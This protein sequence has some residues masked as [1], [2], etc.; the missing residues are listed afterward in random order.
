MGETD[1]VQS[2]MQTVAQN[3]SIRVQ[4]TQSVVCS[5]RPILD[6][7]SGVRTCSR[8]YQR[9]MIAKSKTTIAAPWMMPK[10]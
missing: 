10:R 1:S 8:S 4:T 2:R 6:D 7:E 3:A 9:K 5:K